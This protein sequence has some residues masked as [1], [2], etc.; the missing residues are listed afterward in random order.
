[1]LVEGPSQLLGE[2]EKEEGSYLPKQNGAP[3]ECL[4]HPL[5]PPCLQ[6]AGSEGPLVSVTAW[7]VGNREQE[8]GA[9]PSL[10]GRRPAPTGSP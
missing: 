10:P 5:L 6:A 1:M 3:F 7:E 9:A 8:Q 4:H 2:G